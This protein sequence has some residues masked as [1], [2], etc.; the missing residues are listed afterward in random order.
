MRGL[1]RLMKVIEPMADL[2]PVA[3]ATLIAATSW[4]LFG[5]PGQML[6]AKLATFVLAL[7]RLNIR[8]GKVAMSFNQ[9]AENS[10]RLA[11]LD[12]LLDDHNK[13]FRRTGGRPFQGLRRSIS[14]E[15]V[16][17][18]YPSRDQP[19]LK[20]INLEIPL[21]STLA[22]VGPSGAGKSSLTDLLVGLLAPTGGQIRVDGIDLQ[23]IE[24]NSWQQKIGIVSQDYQVLNASVADN[25]AFGRP[26]V[27][28]AQIEAAASRAGAAGFIAALPQGYDSILGERG[29]RLS[30]G[31]RQRISLARALLAEPDLL[32]LDEATSAL[33]SHSEG[34]ILDNLRALP[35]TRTVVMVAHRLS[36]ITHA[37]RIVVLKDGHIVEEGRHE[38]LLALGGM[39]SGLWQRQAR[40]K[41]LSDR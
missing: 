4:H 32:I 35:G 17:L 18:T 5:G 1:V 40:Q 7:Q 25:I 9:L 16:E 19:T 29:H 12:Q 30:G 41:P 13:Q 23:N 27:S 31:Q 36:S 15:Q 24:L 3:A 11:L 20:A 39:Y 14:F 37:D 6:V 33:D 10:G 38:D 34:Q 26:G 22:M 21:G 2:L 28:L 8:L